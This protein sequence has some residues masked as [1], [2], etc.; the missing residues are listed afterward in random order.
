MLNSLLQQFSKILKTP[1]K[2]YC[3]SDKLICST[4]S[5]HMAILDQDEM[6][7]IELAI[8]FET[9]VLNSTKYKAKHYKDLKS[10]LLQPVFKVPFLEITSFGSISKQS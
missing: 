8:Y 5:Q 2:I 1:R 4:T 9:N 10:Q 7:V 3:D 6:T